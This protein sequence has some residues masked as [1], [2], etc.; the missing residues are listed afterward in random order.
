ML[1]TISPCSLAR[2]SVAGARGLHCHSR[3]QV[4]A[5]FSTTVRSTTD[6]ARGIRTLCR[7]LPVQLG[8]HLPTAF[9]APERLNDVPKSCACRANPSSEG[10]STVFC[11]AAC[12]VVKLFDADASS[13]TR[14]WRQTFVAARVRNNR[15]PGS[16]RVHLTR[17]SAY[18]PSTA[19]SAAPFAPACRCP[20]AVSFVRNSP[21]QSNYHIRLPDAQSSAL[22]PSI[23]SLTCLPLVIS[24]L[25]STSSDPLKWPC[26]LSTS[27]YTPDTRLRVIDHHQCRKCCS[28]AG[29]P[30]VRSA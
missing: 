5:F 27:A 23:V 7:Q 3:L 13:N 24:V 20:C 16:V 12:T 15:R 6:V 2:P 8:N 28:A 1:T 25:L 4:Q 14:H 21:V 29:K 30:C 17:T 18:H 22:D 10:P 26:T 9:A 11:D 19:R